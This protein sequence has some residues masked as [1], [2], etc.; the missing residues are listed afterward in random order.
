MIAV[1]SDAGTWSSGKT[2]WQELGPGLNVWAHSTDIDLSGYALQDLSFFPTGVGVQDPGLYSLY[3]SDTPL[4][5][6][7]VQ[8]I[9]IVT[10]VPLNNE[11]LLQMSNRQLA[12]VGPGMLGS[13]REFETILMGQYRAFTF[14]NSF[15]AIQGTL[16][17]QRSQRFGSG[18]PTAADKLSTYRIVEIFTEPNFPSPFTATDQLK[19]PA[20]RYILN[21]EMVEEDN[22]VHM[23]RLKRSYELANQ[24]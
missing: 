8:V 1:Y 14:D 17:L 12:Q 16:T 19:I 22:L 24:V 7:L 21:G 11:Q 23:M 18:E 10:S 9:D 2:G 20:A 4:T 13:D 3:V 15:T 6:V 5:G